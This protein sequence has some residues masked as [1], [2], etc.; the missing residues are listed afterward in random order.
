MEWNAAI[1]DA[2]TQAAWRHSADPDSLRAAISAESAADLAQALRIDHSQ[3]EARMAAIRRALTVQDDLGAGC[4]L[5]TDEVQGELLE[6]I[7]R[8]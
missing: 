3:A 6:A 5:L 8:L 4:K 2:I 7:N 1:D